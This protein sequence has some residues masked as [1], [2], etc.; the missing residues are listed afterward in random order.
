[1]LFP[2]KI[3]PSEHRM[4][5]LEQESWRYRPR[6]EAL[7][8]SAWV[9]R[10]GGQSWWWDHSRRKGRTFGYFL[11]VGK[12]WSVPEMSCLSI[13]YVRKANTDLSYCLKMPPLP[14]DDIRWFMCRVVPEKKKK[15]H[16][17]TSV[18]LLHSPEYRLFTHW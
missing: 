6:F 10:S 13:T 5:F 4:D 2:I 14:V 1:M 15:K 11:G 18:P 7:G 12:L 8:W 9:T 17:A 3:L 16:S